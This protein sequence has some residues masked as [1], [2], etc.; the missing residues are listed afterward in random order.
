MATS[1]STLNSLL[2]NPYAQTALQGVRN[3]APVDAIKPGTTITARYTVQDD[4]ELAL[5]DVSLVDDALDDGA[6]QGGSNQRA[7]AER[8]AR[9]A[10]FTDFARPRAILN[11][12]DEL[13][14]FAAG[15]ENGNTTASLPA[16]QQK[17]NVNGAGI[18]DVVVE[19]VQ[20]APQTLAAQRQYQVAD[21]YARNSD[22]VYNIN[23]AFSEAA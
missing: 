2:L 1:L 6:G 19:E 21:L 23:P 15:D 3:A 17:Q 12:S 16:G 13:E 20:T 14:L 5:R 8:D 18:T 22:I 7:L 10:S 9:T 4:G 11:P